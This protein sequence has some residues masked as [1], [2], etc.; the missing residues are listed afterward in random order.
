[1]GNRRNKEVWSEG[2]EELYIGK[3]LFSRLLATVVN[4]PSK[5]SLCGHLEILSSGYWGQTVYEFGRL[6]VQEVSQQGAW[7][8]W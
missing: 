5:V 2:R 1:M 3:L 8:E 4:V 7:K 6:L